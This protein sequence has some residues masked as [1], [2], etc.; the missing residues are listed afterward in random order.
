MQALECVGGGT[1]FECA[2]AQEFCAAFFHFLCDSDDLF[3]AFYRAG[4]G[5][6][7]KVAAPHCIAA[8]FQYSIVRMKFPVRDLV[9]FRYAADIFYNV[10]G[11]NSRDVNFRGIADQSPNG[12]LFPLDFRD[13]DIVLF[14]VIVKLVDLFG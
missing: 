5:N 10:L 11:L 2:S 13:L 12:R 9:R 7:I 3:F 8:D 1:R 4:A 6:D 14:Q